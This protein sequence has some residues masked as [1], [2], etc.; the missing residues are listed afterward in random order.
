MKPWTHSAGL[1]LLAWLVG[2]ASAFAGRPLTIDDAAPVATGQLEFELGFAQARPIGG[3]R[4]QKSPTL[5]LTYGAYENLEVGLTIQRI[6]QDGPGS[7][8]VRGFEDLHLN[9]KY[10]FVEES[11][12]LPAFAGALDFKL[13]SA[14]RA[15]GLSTGRSDQALLLIATKT[16]APLALHANLGYRIVGDR[17]GARLNNIPHGGVA[18]EWHLA[19]HWSMV[20][21]ITGAGRTANRARNEANFQLGGRFSA[22]P[23]LLLDLAM[24]RSLSAT[25]TAIQGT[26]GLTWTLNLSNAPRP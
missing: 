18:L 23:N 12:A 11:P 16:F 20:G 8:P 21:E 15:K 6:N 4:D 17:P 7:A 14:S 5:G 22:L 26:F 9:A 19:P 1:A 25:G 3:G 13:P 10:K 24:G 2:C